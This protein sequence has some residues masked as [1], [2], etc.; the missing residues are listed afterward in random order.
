MEIALAKATGIRPDVETKMKDI[1]P[2]KQEEAKSVLTNADNVLAN[3]PDPSKKSKGESLKQGV[4]QGMSKNDVCALDS[5]IASLGEWVRTVAPELDRQRKAAIAR[6]Q[7]ALEEAQRLLNGF[8][9]ILKPDTVAAL[10]SPTDKLAGLLNSSYDAAA[11]DATTRDLK[12]AAERAD[13][14]VRGQMQ[15]GIRNLRALKASPGWSDVSPSRKQWLE[16]NLPSIE[17]GVQEVSNPDLLARFAKEYP[18]ARLEMALASAFAEL[19]DKGDAA[20]AAKTLEDLGPGPRSGSAALN[21]ALSYFYW[22]QGQAA[23]SAGKEALMARAKEAYDAGKS[24][25]VDLASL[26]APLFAPSFVEEMSRR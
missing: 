12:G 5:A 13:G 22:W 10:K 26:G 23:S 25:R 9:G 15:E 24:L 6:D 3:V 7:P 17:K 8:S 19:Y 14:E 4:Q 2:R 11:M 1:L 20:S 21:Y 16:Q 18:R